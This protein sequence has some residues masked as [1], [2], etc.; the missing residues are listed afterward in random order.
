MAKINVMSPGRHGHNQ[1]IPYTQPQRN[2]CKSHQAEIDNI[3][4][5][6]AV[7]ERL[8]TT[9]QWPQEGQH[10][11]M[12]GDDSELFLHPCHQW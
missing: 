9:R 12:R 8:K 5:A 4:Q 10:G 2:A 11:S 6:T 7:R 1:R 3:I